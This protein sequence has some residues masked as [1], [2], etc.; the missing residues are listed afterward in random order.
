MS[1]IGSLR[2]H[3]NNVLG[4]FITGVQKGLLCTKSDYCVCWSGIC[5]N[6]WSCLCSRNTASA[7]PYD[8]LVMMQIPG[9]KKEAVR[10]GQ[11]HPTEPQHL[12]TATLMRADTWWMWPYGQTACTSQ[13]H[14]Y[15]LAFAEVR[16]RYS[17][18]VTEQQGEDVTFSHPVE[19]HCS[20]CSSQRSECSK[21]TLNVHLLAGYEILVLTPA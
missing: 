6:V 16:E 10:C 7:L 11:L 9:E 1:Y 4:F 12:M 2:T 5:V 17:S 21:W 18:K 19:V 15:L 3:L 8:R 20:A 14:T 13:K